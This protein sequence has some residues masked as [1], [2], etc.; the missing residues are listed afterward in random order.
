MLGHLLLKGNTDQL[1]SLKI[2]YFSEE[3]EL[4]YHS[5]ILLPQTVSVNE[6]SML[7]FFKALERTNYAVLLEDLLD[8]KEKYNLNDW[9]TYSL[10]NQALDL[11]FDQQQKLRKKLTNWFFQAL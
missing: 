6:K 3:I 7:S 2:D 10:L 11:V 4:Q 5:S 9:L 1:L 8:K